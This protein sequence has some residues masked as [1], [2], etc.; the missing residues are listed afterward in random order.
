MENLPGG[1]AVPVRRGDDVD[2]CQYISNN[3]T[4]RP[5]RPR[6]ARPLA[7]IGSQP[8]LV[9]D[10]LAVGGVLGGGAGGDG[11]GADDGQEGR[12]FCPGGGVLPARLT[13]GGA[14]VGGADTTAGA[15]CLVIGEPLASAL[16]RPTITSRELRHRQPPRLRR[17]PADVDLVQ[18]ETAEEMR[19]AVVDRLP[20]DVVVM[21]AAVVD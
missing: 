1:N 16:R 10:R 19:A 4:R 8:S 15:C 20:A 17:G 13:R 12:Q 11:C 2:K 7:K 9:D 14:V 21:A 3:R 6:R 5:A 18:V